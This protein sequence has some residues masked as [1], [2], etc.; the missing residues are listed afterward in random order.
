MYPTRSRGDD[1]SSTGSST[2]STQRTRWRELRPWDVAADALEYRAQVPPEDKT[3]TIPV[4][5]DY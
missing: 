4:W 3:N 1:T 5:P 2:K